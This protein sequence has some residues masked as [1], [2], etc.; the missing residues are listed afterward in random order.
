M[1]KQVELFE[2]LYRE[3]QEDLDLLAMIIDEY[4]VAL[5]E[6]DKLDELEDFLANNF[7]KSWKTEKSKKVKKLKI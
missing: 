6:S 7:G 5:D 2:F 4:I 1:S 3:C